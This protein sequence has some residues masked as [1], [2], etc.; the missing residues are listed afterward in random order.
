MR[1]FND[2]NN[3][4]KFNT[5]VATIGSF[6]GVHLGH[7]KL[8][9]RIV[10]MSKEVEGES[11]MITFHPHPRSIV[12]PDNV[13]L[14]TTLDEKC[15]ILKN[16]K[17]DN[18]IIV[19]FDL[20]FSQQTPEEYIEN[21]LIKKI[22]PSCLVIGY[23]HRFGKNRQGDIT[24]LRKYG[25]NFQHGIHEISKKEI[26]NITISS[27]KIRKYLKS[28]NLEEANG[29][30]DYYYMLSGTVVTGDKIGREI[31]YPTA[32]VS[33][34]LKQK[35]IP[36]HGV[37][38][39]R[40]MVEGT[41]YDG[42]LYIGNRP[43]IDNK[44]ETKIE[45]NLFDF[46]Q[47]IYH[48]EITLSIYNFIREDKKLDSLDALQIQ[49]SKDKK[50]VQEYFD[51]FNRYIRNEK[52]LLSI[53]ILTYNS[54][55]RLETFLPSIGDSYSNAFKTIIVDNQS[56]DDSIEFVTDWFP[57]IQTIQFRSNY[58]YAKGYNKAV[59]QIDSKYI[60][61]LND[62]VMV[63]PNWLSPIIKLME[64][65]SSIGACMPSILDYNNK[66]KYEYAG[67]A[68]GLLDKL[69]VPFCIGRVF[70][71][72][73]NINPNYN[74]TNEVFWAS[75]AALVIRKDVFINFEGFDESFFAHQEEIDFCWRIKNA[76]FK[77]V[78]IPSSKVYH[79]GGS[80][81]SYSDPKKTYLNVRN[82]HWM[83]IKNA[84]HTNLFFLLFRRIA[85]DKIGALYLITKGR[86]AE[87]FAVLKGLTHAYLKINTMLKRRKYISKLVSKFKIGK[88]N[89]T[90]MSNYSIVNKYYLQ[91]KKTYHKIIE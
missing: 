61:L 32:N 46:D 28:G 85:H 84:S 53:A 24:L 45:I 37:Y 13:E 35:L 20:S 77:V 8:I 65:D 23:D 6:D 15:E 64:N 4:P 22:N 69:G 59:S 9:R 31:G 17:I 48:K 26:E 41:V 91:G 86:F 27:S 19:P 29:L 75:G 78:S 33:V 74:Q 66:D 36:A 42:M 3:L 89:L 14:L 50:N 2:I 82:N 54:R 72:V 5:G 25:K 34:S 7:R 38:A 90:G 88:V 68:G 62:D 21:F 67:A 55:D 87:A 39:A 47:E 71:T 44:V 52:S 79:V 57:E 18:L 30:L 40:A 51:K 16:L 81:L 12:D 83:L 60:V 10:Q 63:T 76:G 70:D 73:E 49:L 56:D 80:S 1:I 43:S 11:I 58:G